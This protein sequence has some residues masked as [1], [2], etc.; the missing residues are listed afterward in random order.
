MIRAVVTRGPS[1]AEGTFGRL[2]APGLR[3]FTGELPWIGNKPNIS[4]IPTGTYKCVWAWSVH[5]RREMY[6]LEKVPGRSGVRIHAANFVGSKEAG[7][8]SQLAGCI[9]L[10]EKLGTMSGQRALLLS[11]PAVRKFEMLLAKKPFILEVR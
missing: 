5:F 7:Y 10:G 1:T 9:A 4:S 3:L 2:E 6:L 11:A 8:R